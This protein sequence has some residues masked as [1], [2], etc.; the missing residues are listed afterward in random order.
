MSEADQDIRVKKAEEDE[1]EEI[2][3]PFDS[4]LEDEQE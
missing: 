1:E 4:G 3:N 2:S